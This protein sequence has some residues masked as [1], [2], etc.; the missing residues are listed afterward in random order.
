MKHL[1]FKGKYLE[2]LMSKEKK[3]TIR[4]R[5]NLKPNDEVFIH[6]G[7]KIIGKAKIRDVKKIK[8]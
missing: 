5:A 2:K 6:C 1:E 4:R 8:I 3:T 7:G